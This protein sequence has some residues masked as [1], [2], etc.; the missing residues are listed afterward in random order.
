ML[1]ANICTTTRDLC[2]FINNSGIKREDIQGIIWTN[3]AY[4]IFYWE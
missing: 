1:R 4:T 2:A 3:G